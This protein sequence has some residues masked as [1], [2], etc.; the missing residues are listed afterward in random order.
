MGHVTVGQKVYVVVASTVDKLD[1]ATAMTKV[2][3]MG[4]RWAVLKDPSLAALSAVL[5]ANN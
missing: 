3:S 1:G 4:P 5:W 2:D